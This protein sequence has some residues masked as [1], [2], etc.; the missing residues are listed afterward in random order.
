MSIVPKIELSLRLL[1]LMT[2]RAFDLAAAVLSLIVVSPLM[3]A[4]ALLIKLQDGGPIFYRGE[5]I[6]RQG[7][8]FH[9]LKFRTMVPNAE[10]FGSSCTAADDPRITLLGR[11]L[12][13][14]KL[15]ELPQLI[16][17]LLGDMSVVGPR[18]DTPDYAAKL[19]AE[20]ASLVF[21]VRPGITDWA[22]LWNYDEEDFLKGKGNPDRAYMELIW[23]T[24]IALQVAYVRKRSLATDLRIVAQTIKVIIN[25]SSQNSSREDR[26]S[27]YGY[28][29][30][31]PSEL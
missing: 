4:V 23:P 31:H 6:G 22:T 13:R 15:D 21:S 14:Y 9:M 25:R 12:R 24:K 5:R 2:K 10:Q 7:K 16:N 11:T 27:R 3:L 1:D 8:T 28:E 20:Q 26:K 18:P 30:I 17:V 29:D 19:S